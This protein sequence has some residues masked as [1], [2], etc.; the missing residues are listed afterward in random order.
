MTN[1][2]EVNVTLHQKITK[3]N[4]SITKVS[5]MNKTSKMQIL[6]TI[7][8]CLYDNLILQFIGIL[9]SSSTFEL[10]VVGAKKGQLIL[11][12]FNHSAVNDNPL[13]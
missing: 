4:Q 3:C 7:R 5:F 13:L 1:E 11:L 12:L 6:L 10:I 8:L 2:N 9:F